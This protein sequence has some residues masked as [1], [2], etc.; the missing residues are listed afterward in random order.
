M[1]DG[2]IWGRGSVDDKSGLIGSLTAVETLIEQ[3]FSPRRTVMLAFGFDEEASGKQVCYSY[4]V[5][6]MEWCSIDIL[7]GSASNRKLSN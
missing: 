5:T 1:Q 3:G 4:L 2:W 6:Y 7:L